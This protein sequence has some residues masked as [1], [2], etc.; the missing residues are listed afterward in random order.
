MAFNFNYI[1]SQLGFERHSEAR[2]IYLNLYE[3]IKKGIEEQVFKYDTKL[4]PSRVLAKDLN[5]SRSTVIKA[6]EMLVLDNYVHSKVGSG[7]YINNINA[8]LVTSFLLKK[9]SKSHYPPISKRGQSFKKNISINISNSTTK[10]IA[11]RPGLPPLDTFPVTQWKNIAQGYWKSVRSSELSY[12]TN[13]NLPELQRSIAH[14]LRIYR[15]INCDPNHIIITTGA[16]H[17]LSLICDALVD[18]DDEVI[19]ENPTFPSASQLCKSLKAKIHRANLDNEG[20]NL[21]QIKSKSPKFIYTTP[22]NQYPT[23]IKMSLNRKKE[24]LKWSSKK[25]TLIIEDDYDHEFSNWKEPTSSIFSLDIENRVI[26]IGTFNKL[27]HPSIRIGYMIVPPYL[28][29][30]ILSIS[31]QSYRFVSI[32]LQKTLNRF[33]A[34]GYLNKHIRNVIEVSI[35]R[36]EVF[37]SH[38]TNA[39]GDAINIDPGNQGLHIIGRFKQSIDDELFS[40]HLLESNIIAH[41]LSKYFRK[42][43]INK[44]L[45]MGYSSVNNKVI[46]ETIDKMKKSYSNFIELY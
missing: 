45:V 9:K 34:K 44:G 11:F 8:S 23:G 14:Y 3:T 10:G 18:P 36:K 31:Q 35:E 28:L 16:L 17:S 2:T 30:P 13:M 22:S 5:I 32:A 20:I 29:D 25:K 43:S 27:L 1:L 39:F 21:E 7:Y 15:N 4:P 19:L 38:F 12:P 37:S 41:P 24:L 46:K 40:D 6:Y 26:Y 33:I 42:N